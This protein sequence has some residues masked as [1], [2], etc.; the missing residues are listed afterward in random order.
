MSGK[1]TVI[2]PFEDLDIPEVAL[3]Q[4]ISTFFIRPKH[5]ALF[6]E[7][8]VNT[9]KETLDY[10][11]EYKPQRRTPAGMHPSTWMKALR[12]MQNMNG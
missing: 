3:Q 1:G 7:L 6:Q 5:V 8:G 10:L 11:N 9:V 4:P 2:P 12:N